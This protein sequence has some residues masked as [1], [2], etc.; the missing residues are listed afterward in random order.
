M[1]RL[2]RL[3]QERRFPNCRTLAGEFEVS[4]KTIQ[5]DVEFMR[6]RMGLP[7]A[8]D[9]LHFGFTYSEPVTGFPTLEVSEGELVALFVAQKALEQYHG[10]SFERPLRTAFEKMSRALRDRIAF[11]WDDVDAAI[12]FKTIGAAPADLQV[13]DAVSKAVLNSQE[14]AFE[15]RKLSGARHEVRRVEPLHLACIENQWYLFGRDLV[16]RELRTYALP[17]MRKARS[18]GIG[19]ARPANFSIA[20]V[21][22]QSFG[23]FSGRGRRRITIRFDEFAA[24][25]VGER[26][27]HP[28][29]RMRALPGGTMELSLVLGAFEEIERWI[30]S[31]GVHAEVIAPLELRERLRKTTFALSRTYATRKR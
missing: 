16:R 9:Q 30:L 8:Y 23:V 24:R 20:E 25:L 27:W 5:R 28:S 6:D 18:T 29:Q 17:R 22:E 1:L 15:Y 7:I 14:L 11:R 12:S 13:F 2:H 21:L 31:W 4:S 26:H 19:F 3:I 10:T